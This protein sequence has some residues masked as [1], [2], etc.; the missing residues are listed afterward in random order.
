MEWLNK[1]LEEINKALMEVEN[2]SLTN[3]TKMTVL[4]VL[5]EEIQSLELMKKKINVDVDFVDHGFGK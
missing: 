4:K 1:K 2:S 5:K 3:E